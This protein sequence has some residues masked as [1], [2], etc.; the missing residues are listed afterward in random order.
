MSL[1]EN[2]FAWI[3]AGLR[4][5]LNLKQIAFGHSAVNWAKD[6]V[7]CALLCFCQQLGSHRRAVGPHR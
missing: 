2:D 6:C 1:E 5:L 4:G 7:V 3:R